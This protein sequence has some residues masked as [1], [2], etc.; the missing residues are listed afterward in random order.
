[1]LCQPSLSCCRQLLIRP[2]S[3]IFRVGILRFHRLLDDLLDLWDLQH[4]RDLG[5]V[6]LRQVSHQPCGGAQH[7][8]R[9]LHV[10]G[11]RLYELQASLLEGD[12]GKEGVEGSRDRLGGSLEPVHD[13]RVPVQH[14]L[15]QR[16]EVHPLVLVEPLGLSQLLLELHRSLAALLQSRKP[17]LQ[18]LVHPC[19]DR[20]RDVPEARVDRGLDVVMHLAELRV[21]LRV[22]ER[23]EQRLHNGVGVREH[24]GIEL[25]CNVR[26]RRHRQ[27]AQ[28]RLLRRRDARHQHRP[29][30]L[31]VPVEASLGKGGGHG[32][33]CQQRLLR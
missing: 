13:A 10:G 31:H 19:P 14:P 1:M 4:P 15:H 8:L 22:G 28:R 11:E 20:H 16:V 5:P 2:L 18:V 7:A 9:L 17:V 21:N 32:A 3:N 12:G 25:P 29:K 33:H 24:L 23:S 6:S 27:H 26:R 30:R